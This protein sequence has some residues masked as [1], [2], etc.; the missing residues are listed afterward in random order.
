[1]TSHQNAHIKK[2]RLRYTKDKLSSN[3]T[4]LSIVFN[5]LYFV[6]IYRS[7]VGSYYYTWIIGVSV[8]YNLLFMLAAFLSSEGVKAYKLGYSFV[9]L[10]IGAGQLIRISILPKKAHETFLSMNGEEILAMDDGQFSWVSFCL[11]ASAA[12]CIAA[13]LISLVKTRTLT[14]YLKELRETDGGETA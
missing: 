9:L 4:L 1:M 10:A 7:D 12:L 14:S 5:A 3:L 2:D 13:G 8:V 6:S 11:F